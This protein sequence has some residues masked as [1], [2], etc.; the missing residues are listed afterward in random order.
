ME[1]QFCLSYLW[2]STPD[3]WFEHWV[4]CSLLQIVPESGEG[5]GV[6]AVSHFNFRVAPQFSFRFLLKKWKW[7]SDQ[8]EP[9]SLKVHTE[10]HNNWESRNWLWGNKREEEVTEPRHPERNWRSSTNPLTNCNL[11]GN[12]LTN[13]ECS[14]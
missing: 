14:I 8:E 5:E 11:T 3:L 13:W 2:W 6:L 1:I 12:Q 10:T 7:S 9:K 4:G